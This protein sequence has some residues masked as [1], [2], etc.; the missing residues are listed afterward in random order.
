MGKYFNA[1][2]KIMNLRMIVNLMT[3]HRFLIHDKSKRK[4]EF[5]AFKKICKMIN[6]AT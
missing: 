6:D 1:V 5:T 3:F 2:E 4:I